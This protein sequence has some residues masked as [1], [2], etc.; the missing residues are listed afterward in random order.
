[1]SIYVPFLEGPLLEVLL[2]TI[3]EMAVVMKK[4]HTRGYWQNLPPKD[5][6]GYDV[7]KLNLTKHICTLGW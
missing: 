4:V 5:I 2:Y 1:V 3:V 7:M 6:S